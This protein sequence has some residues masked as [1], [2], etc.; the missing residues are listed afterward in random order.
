M[1]AADAAKR[2][3]LLGPPNSGKGTQ[4]AL[5]A[6]RLGIPAISTGDML[7]AARDAGTELGG[8]VAGIMA[9][10]QLVDD[11]TMKEVVRERLARADTDDGFLLDGYPRTMRQVKD[12]EEIVGKTGGV[13]RVLHIRVPEDELVRRGLARGRED[14][15]EDVIRERL[16]VYEEKTEPLIGYYKKLGLLREVDGHRP[17]EDVASQLLQAVGVE[18]QEGVAS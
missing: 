1:A 7:R 4:A 18:L 12:F 16:K 3:I 17:I 5:L 15:R 6:E 13:D 10:G 9:A 14:D 11:D 2:L 8:K